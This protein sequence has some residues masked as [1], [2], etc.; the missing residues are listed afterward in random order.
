MNPVEAV[1]VNCDFIS[2]DFAGFATFA[3]GSRIFPVQIQNQTLFRTIR[4]RHFIALKI[5]FV[6]C[7]NFQFFLSLATSCNF[8]LPLSRYC[9]SWCC[10][11]PSKACIVRSPPGLLQ[12]TGKEHP[13]EHRVMSY[14]FG[15]L[16]C[17]TNS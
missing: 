15:E 14:I 6:L 7:T 5:S 2:E 8:P 1:M 3:H 10:F 13:F 16:L 12:E 11:F 9:L 4:N 17:L